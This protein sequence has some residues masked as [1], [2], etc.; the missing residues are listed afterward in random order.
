MM[1]LT[2]TALFSVDLLRLQQEEN[3]MEERISDDVS[4]RDKRNI[5]HAKSQYCKD[6]G[7]RLV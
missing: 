5:A 2:S 7:D 6:C 4:E 3:S 1:N